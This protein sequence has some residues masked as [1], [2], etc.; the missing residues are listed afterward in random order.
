MSATT[1]ASATAS[2]TCLDITPGKNGYLPPES[3][4]VIL[5]YVP[6]FAAAVLFCVLFGLTTILHGVQAVLYKKTYTWVIIMGGTW[7]LLAFIFRALQTRQQDKDYWATLHT[8]F[9]LLAPIWINAF[10]YMTLGRMIHYFIPAKKLAHI[11]AR[12]YGLLFVLLDIFAFLVQLGGAGLTTDTDASE[13][14]IML[15]LHI[16]MGGIG[17][18]EFFILC[19]TGLLIKMHLLMVRMESSHELDFEKLKGG[20]N[21]RW[22]F[23]AIYFS[24]G[25]IT[26]RIIFRLAQ[27]AQGTSATNPVLTHEWFEYVFDAAPMFLSLLALNVFHPGRILQGPD[28]D[29]PKVTRAE[30]KQLKREKKE[31]KMRRKAEKKTG[32]PQSTAYMGAQPGG[33]SPVDVEDHTGRWDRQERFYGA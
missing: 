20:F 27:Y 33:Y 2:P 13:K 24:L 8:M 10:I 23:Y 11:S 16:Y 5:Y 9:F 22:L 25:M 29:F 31:M 12:R 19:F 32:V 18:Q 21:W 1:T 17:L 3:C 14:T 6:S 15:G 4:D 26:I 30:K 7:E 28:A